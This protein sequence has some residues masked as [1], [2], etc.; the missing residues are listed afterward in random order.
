MNLLAS[1][2]LS[3]LPRRYRAT[4]TP[5]EIPPAGAIVSGILETLFS[6]GLMIHGYIAYTTERT[7]AIPAAVIAGAGEKGGESAIMGLGAIILLEY[8]LRFTT[9]LLLFFAFEGLVRA[10]AAVAAGEVLPSL[11]LQ[12]AA[13][14]HTQLDAKNTEKRL[15]ERIADEVKSV[16]AEESLKI[17][18]CRPKTW[19]RL[20][21]ISYEGEFYELAAQDKGPAP[22][23][24]VYTLRKKPVTAVIRGICPYDPNEVLPTTT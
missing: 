14:V 6:L 13:I 19:T 12:I 10:I 15:G 18:S 1:L 20:T 4:F 8:L 2:S 21:T 17:A 23:P 24:Y 7:A 9:I 16:P 22:R 11:P 3:F 5:H